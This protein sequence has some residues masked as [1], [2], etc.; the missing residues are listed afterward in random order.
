MFQPAGVASFQAAKAASI[1]PPTHARSPHAH[2]LSHAGPAVVEA[3]AALAALQPPPEVA[4]FQAAKEVF[5]EI[6]KHHPILRGIL[7]SLISEVG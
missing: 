3:R 2:T 4:S 1:R 7:E 5:D 6:G